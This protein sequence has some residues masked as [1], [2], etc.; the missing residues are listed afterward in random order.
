M[1]KP[2]CAPRKGCAKSHEIGV[3]KVMTA[4]MSVPM[5]LGTLDTAV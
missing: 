2:F 4:C 3:P 5:E 1:V